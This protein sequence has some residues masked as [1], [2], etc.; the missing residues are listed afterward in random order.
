M[1]SQNGRLKPSLLL[2]L[3]TRKIFSTF[4]Y[5]C[6]PTCYHRIR[7]YRTKNGKHWKLQP[8]IFFHFRLHYTNQYG[9]YTITK[10]IEKGRTPHPFLSR[11]RQQLVQVLGHSHS[12]FPGERKNL[13]Q[14][15]GTGSGRRVLL[16]GVQ[17]HQVPTHLR[18]T[19]RQPLFWI[20][21]SVN[22]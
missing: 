18:L 6:S 15:S 10:L 20:L 11:G 13:S 4:K 19:S 3:E 12:F 7:C 22:L 2:T 9:Q 16:H 1:K 5:C 17:F 8:D 14:A 21:S